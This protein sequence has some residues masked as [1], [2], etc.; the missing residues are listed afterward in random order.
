MRRGFRGELLSLND[1]PSF[2]GS[3]AINHQEDGIIV[4]EKGIIIARG[5][6][7]KITSD[8]PDLPVTHFPNH[9][10]MP[11]FIDSHIHY[12]QVDCIASGGETLLGWLEKKVFP[13]EAQFQDKSYALT[14]AEFFLNECLRNGT[15][16]ALVFAGSQPQSVEALYESAFKADM[17]I[18]VGKVLMDLGPENLADT[19]EGGLLDSKTLI[20]HWQGH[21]RLNYA[22][23]PRFALTSSSEQ[24]A[25]AGQ[26]LNEYPD[27]I[28]QT[29]LAETKAECAAVKERF[30][31]ARDYLEVYEHFGLVTDRSVFAHCLYL[32][33]SAFERL[34]NAGAGI[35][36]CPTS[37]LFLGS[38]LFNFMEAQRH[39]VKIGLGSD[40]G[41]GTSFSLLATMGEAYKVCRL[42]GYNLD[43]F[44]ALYLATLGGARLLR[45]DR[46]IGALTVGQ[47]ADFIVIDPAATPLLARRT[48]D[49]SLAEKLFALQIMGDDRVI[50]ASYIKGKPLWEKPAMRPS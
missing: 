12:S 10:I 30:P 11:G 29:H 26:I 36:F 9:L 18:I 49:A 20:Q 6:T 40:I 31:K 14:T 25:G 3:K 44:H 17:R 16:T 28:M 2:V 50:A 35:A 42:Q 46:Y 13:I 23:T 22:V 19:T 5:S 37:N 4:I 7:E 45:L 8:F 27:I 15:T 21:G 24:L 41:A 33:D 47:E 34:S 38:G 39:S 48:A 32:T 1:D 43:P